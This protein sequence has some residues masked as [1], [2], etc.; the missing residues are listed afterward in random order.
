LKKKN[1]QEQEIESAFCLLHVLE[2]F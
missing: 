2:Q 1:S